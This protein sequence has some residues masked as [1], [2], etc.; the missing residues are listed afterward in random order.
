MII[1]KKTSNTARDLFEDYGFDLENFTFS[2]DVKIRE[3]VRDL[4]NVILWKYVRVIK[5]IDIP[6]ELKKLCLDETGTQESGYVCVI[7]V[8]ILDANTGKKQDVARWIQWFEIKKNL[9]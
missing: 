2:K 3:N 8:K 6:H 9:F 4:S 5:Q 7:K 1:K